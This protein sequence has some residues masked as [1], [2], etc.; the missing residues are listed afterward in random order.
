[1]A[2]S[3]TL[4]TPNT[5]NP[6]EKALEDEAKPAMEFV[7][8][9]KGRKPTGKGP[10][11]KKQPQR[12][13]GVEKLE[14]L[15]IQERWKKM[16]EITA[17]STT[18]FPTDPIGTSNVPVLHGVGN[19]GVPMM[20]NGGS[21]GLWSWGDTAGLVMQRV[22]GNGGFGGLNGQCLVGAPGNVQVAC[23]VGVMEA[24]K[25]LSS[26]PKLQHCKPDRCDVCFKV[27]FFFFSP[28]F[29]IC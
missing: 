20:I 23:G 9:N 26:I 4:S 28:F 18:Q 10:Y 12:G 15:R 7:K 22:V 24:S 13:M 3:L 8:S 25:E 27:L 21:G 6:T 5:N 19:Y 17:T 11:Q 16:T 14:R 2:T 29:L 1:M